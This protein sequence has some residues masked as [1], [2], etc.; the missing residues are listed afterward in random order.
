[1]KRRTLKQLRAKLEPALHHHVYVVLLDPVVGKFRKVL[2]T[3]TESGG[4]G[5]LVARALGE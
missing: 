3:Y 4:K 1:M 2:V 5:E